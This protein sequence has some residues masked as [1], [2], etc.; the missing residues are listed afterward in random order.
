MD[1]RRESPAAIAELI[2]T[3]VRPIICQYC[4][5][6]YCAI[7]QVEDAIVVD[8]HSTRKVRLGPSLDFDVNQ[9]PC[10]FAILAEH[11][12]ELI[13]KTPAQSCLANDLMELLI[14]GL[15]ALAPVDVSMNRREE[16][17]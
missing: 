6:H 10:L 4:Q 1:L 15:I 12:E 17:C 3:P 16:E 2:R 5:A 9:Q 11:F 8:K 7:I 13:R 14:Q